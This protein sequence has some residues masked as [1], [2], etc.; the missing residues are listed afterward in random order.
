MQECGEQYKRVN[1]NLQIKDVVPADVS[2][3]K[4]GGPYC[5]G[6]YYGKDEDGPIRQLAADLVNGF[7][8]I[9]VIIGIFYGSTH[10]LSSSKLRGDRRFLSLRHRMIGRSAKRFESST[11]LT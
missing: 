5:D 4:Q 1:H 11:K 3:T 10:D 9:N 6:T 2:G 8:R 7:R